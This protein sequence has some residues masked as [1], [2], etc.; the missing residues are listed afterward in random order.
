MTGFT[1]TLQ[2]LRGEE[3]DSNGGICPQGKVER[4]VPSKD[5]SPQSPNWLRGMRSKRARLLF[6]QSLNIFKHETS[7]DKAGRKGGEIRR[8]T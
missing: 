7:V 6:K 4:D 5:S 3:R 8:Q 1:F 2:P